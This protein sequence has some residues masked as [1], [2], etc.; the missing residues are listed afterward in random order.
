MRNLE[1]NSHY[2]IYN[3]AVSKQPIFRE[4]V[5]YRYFMFKLSQYM[6]KY[7]ID[8]FVYCILPNHFHLLLRSHSKAENISKFMQS[9]QRVYGTYFNKKY[10]HSGHVFESKFCHKKAKTSRDLAGVKKYILNN[11]VKHGYVDKYYEWSYYWICPY[12]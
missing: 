8:I 1:K 7:E 5:D 11:P 6:R 12:L 9:L 2:H 3:R 10:N 4:D